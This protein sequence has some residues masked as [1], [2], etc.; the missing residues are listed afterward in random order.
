[1][2]EHPELPSGGSTVRIRYS[3]PC[4]GRIKKEDLRSE[5]F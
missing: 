4:E 3:P 2:V 1:M 5:D